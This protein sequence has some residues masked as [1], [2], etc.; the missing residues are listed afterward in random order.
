MLTI[1]SSQEENRLPMLPL[2]ATLTRRRAKRQPISSRKKYRASPSTRAI[3]LPPEKSARRR[4]HMYLMLLASRLPI[5]AM[6]AGSTTTLPMISRPGS[7]A[8]LRS[9]WARNGARVPTCGVWRQWCLNLSRATISSTRNPEPST[10]RTT[11][12]SHRSSSF[13]VPFPSRSACRAN[14]PRKYSTAKASCVTFTV[15]V[16]GLWQMSSAK[17]ITSRRRRR[18]GSLIS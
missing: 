14:G 5:W 4:M 8:H 16:T 2:S 11:T 18:S 3:R 1:L 7:I 15:C 12:T 17:S 13:S 9:Y 6:P 10:A